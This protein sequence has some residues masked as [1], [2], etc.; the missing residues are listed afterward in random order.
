MLRINLEIDVGA[1][2]REVDTHM[3][4]AFRPTVVEAL[5]AAGEADVDT[6]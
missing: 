4:K 3:L 6:V 1:F 2:E 5:N